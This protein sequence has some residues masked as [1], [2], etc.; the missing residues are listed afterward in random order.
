M[1]IVLSVIRCPENAVPEQRRV[2]GGECVIGRDASC[3]WVL[4]DDERALSKRHC[5][6]EFL[7]GA[8]QVRDHSTNG[9][10]LNGA[11]VSLGRGR[12]YEL[13]SGDRLRLG[14]F[15]I[16]C[17]IEKDADLGA[18]EWEVAALPPEAGLSDPLDDPFG[19]H[20]IGAFADPPPLRDHV[21]HAQDAF[22]PPRAII[23][24]A[25]PEDWN[26]PTPLSTGRSVDPFRDLPD[27]FADGPP[28]FRPAPIA[29][30]PVAADPFVDDPPG[31]GLSPSVPRPVGRGQGWPSAL[32]SA[33]AP[34]A[35]SVAPADLHEAAALLLATA[36][37]P[38]PKPGQDPRVV[39]E[40]AGQALR[41]LVA[42]LRGLLVARTSVKGE[43][44][45][46][47]TMLRASGNNAFKF[48]FS[49]EAA[50]E[51]VLGPRAED[52]IREALSDL[53][54]HQ[55]ATV[56]ATQAAARSLIA[57]LA[58]GPIEQAAGSG[59]LLG[60]REKRMWA[61]YC[62]LHREMVEQFDDDFDSA[63]GKAFTRAYEQAPQLN[64]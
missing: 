20:R 40:R 55:L 2:A 5:V 26:T 58:P 62:K 56:S 63:F 41:D 12:I 36:G 3:D 51:D 25:L 6:V 57:R 16:D 45:I 52:A 27:P 39:L 46:D 53:S 48:A 4:T 9:T 31:A 24:V 64:D 35:G 1:A 44:R 42:G 49:N 30:A 7:A 34:P 19:G 43:L 18:G 17:L 33:A 38:A 14:A 61:A 32:S 21:P 11:A 13:R 54:A 22:I 8:W 28:G 10:F 60:S 37:L 29:P 15:E 47:Q 59:G 23:P 50:L